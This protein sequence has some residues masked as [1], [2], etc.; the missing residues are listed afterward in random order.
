MMLRIVTALMTLLMPGA[1]P[2]PTSILMVAR[3]ELAI[4]DSNDKVWLLNIQR[5]GPGCQYLVTRESTAAAYGEAPPRH[6]NR[7]PPAEPARRGQ[8]TPYIR[9][10]WSFHRRWTRAVHSQSMRGNENW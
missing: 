8:R 3:E 1:G 5:K 2:P 6:L 4:R 10:T 9:D 7:V